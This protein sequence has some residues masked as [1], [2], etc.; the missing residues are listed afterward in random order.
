MEPPSILRLASRLVLV[1]AL[2]PVFAVF[3]AKGRYELVTKRVFVVEDGAILRGAAQRV[4]PYDRMVREHDVRT[5]LNLLPDDPDDRHEVA[6]STVVVDHELQRVRHGM[7]D[8]DVGDFDRLEAA[9]AVLADPAN[10]PVYVHCQ[11]GLHRTGAVVATYRLK[12]LGWSFED[13]VD[14]MRAAGIDWEVDDWLRDNMWKY[15]R[16]RILDRPE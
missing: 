7:H 13:A 16:E 6:E 9:A 2:I 14:E 11:A 3:V 12:H 10:H 1:T 15:Y 5:V 8:L 4:M